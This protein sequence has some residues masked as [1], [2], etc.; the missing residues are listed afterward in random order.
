MK[1]HGERKRKELCLQ[2][3]MDIRQNA[4]TNDHRSSQIILQISPFGGW[5]VSLTQKHT[6]TPMK[7][8]VLRPVSALAYTAACSFDCHL[9]KV[10]P[11]KLKPA[12]VEF[13][14]TTEPVICASSALKIQNFWAKKRS[15][16]SSIHQLLTHS[17]IIGWVLYD[18]TSLT[19]TN[20]SQGPKHNKK[21]KKSKKKSKKN[22]HQSQKRLK[23]LRFLS[24]VVFLFVFVGQS[25]SCGEILRSHPGFPRFSRP[26]RACRM[27][28]WNKWWTLRVGH[29]F[30]TCLLKNL[31][32][33][34]VAMQSCGKRSSWSF[35]SATSWN[36]MKLGSKACNSHKAAVS[37]P[38]L[39]LVK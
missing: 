1:N 10:C 20:P 16:E 12:R 30:W 8:Q 9:R 15:R 31:Q 32:L 2:N 6:S 27:V 28:A 21:S 18:I 11:P 14:W 3:K 22:K 17:E 36:M 25:L 33:L 37:W 7:H 35:W 29:V 39:A 5:H 13:L 19:K 34:Q 23:R 4:S 24:E 38:T 26:T